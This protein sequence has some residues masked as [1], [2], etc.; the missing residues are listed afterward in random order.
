MYR[1]DFYKHI[2]SLNSDQLKE[3]CIK[4]YEITKDWQE[5]IKEQSSAIKHLK[6][7]NSFLE[8]MLKIRKK[9]SL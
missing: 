1:N 3:L 6:K 7:Y 2:D 8:I 9:F 4:L 5:I